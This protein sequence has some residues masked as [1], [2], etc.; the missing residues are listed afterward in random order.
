[1]PKRT[2]PYIGPNKTLVNGGR[3]DLTEDA[4]KEMPVATVP[5]VNV[6]IDDIRKKVAAHIQGFDEL[7]QLDDREQF[8]KD[9]ADECA[10]AQT[11]RL[12]HLTKGTRTKPDEWTTQILAR[13]LASIMQRHGLKATISEYEDSN[14]DEIRQ[15]LYL[16][17]IPRVCGILFPVPKDVKGLALRARR[18]E[19]GSIVNRNKRR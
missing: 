19:H 1:M 4:N 3:F 11:M 18:I 6:D 14:H 13:G 5:A 16:C 17:L 9:I 8:I 7:A 2:K 10:W 15:S 12:D